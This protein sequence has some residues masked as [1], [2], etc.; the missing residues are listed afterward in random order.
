MAKLTPIINESFSQ[1]AGAVLQS[2]ALV[3]VRD[4]LKPSARQIFYCL[5]TDKFLPSKPFKKTLKAIGSIAR[6][7]IH[8]DASAEGVIM[9][10]SQPFAMRYPLVDVEGN[11]GHLQMSG[12]WA[13][14]RY[15]SSR[16]SPFSVC[17]FQDLEKNTITEW[18]DNYDDTE[19]YPTVLPSKGFYNIVN[20][21]FGIG[22]GAASSIP[23]FNLREVNNA[24]IKL[25]WNPDATFDEIYCVPDFATGA[26]LLNAD[27]VKEAMRRG[28]G[29]ACKLR[30]VIEYDEAERCLIVREIPFGVYTNTICKELDTLIERTDNPGIERYNDLTGQTINIKIYLSKRANL[31]R[32]LK[33][34]FKNTSLQSHYSINMTML[35]DG[36]FPKVFGWKA[37]LK[38]HLD[39]EIEV[40]RRGYQYDLDKA[41]DR[42]HIVEGII[43]AI[44][45]LEEVI[46]CIKGSSSTA[47]A[48]DE[49]CRRFEF[50][51]AQAEAILKITLAR[52][53]RLEVAKYENEAAELR[54]QI[55]WLEK[56]L[57]DD[58]TLL[59]QEIEKG[60]RQIASK[61]GDERRT[62]VLNIE[63]DEEEEPVD[64]KILT[65]YLTNY[66]NLYITE[67]S[68]LVKQARGG[69][70]KR[71]KLASDEVIT[72]S[73]IETNVK[74]ILL[75]SSLGRAF[76]CDLN[77]FP[78][79]QKINLNE[80]FA[81]EEDEIISYL[82]AN[83]SKD[84]FVFITREGLIKKTSVH[85]YE[86]RLKRGIS[87]IK[88][89]DGDSIVSI[90]EANDKDTIAIAT[91]D[92]HMTL[93]Q[94]N[95]VP[96]TGRVTSG[97][98]SMTLK[99][100]TKVQDAAIINIETKEIVTVTQKGFA[101]STSVDE[102]TVG[103]RG[104]RGILCHALKD[105]DKLA[106]F[107][108]ISATHR[109]QRRNLNVIASRSTIKIALSDIPLSGRNTVGLKT[110]KLRDD[111]QV[112][113]IFYE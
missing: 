63:R 58:H 35:E 43:R 70:G 30:S 109:E 36:R 107:V 98:K 25:L 69:V 79:D 7:Y 33:F 10:A 94:I 14:P 50:S 110:I 12:T 104:N 97:V 90:V 103:G 77:D 91:D 112:M 51:Y 53:A 86:G 73:A 100:L 60:F 113:E 52:L 99:N 56:V 47:N 17:L 71:V 74:P 82:T 95:E 78:I 59:Y 87:A 5:Y 84:Y 68:S 11:N 22:I 83:P 57:S 1:Y 27:E 4:C 44:S 28:T 41:R 29:A 18:R 24:L 55:E 23:Q 89:K 32:V 34:L 105:G 45:I 48:K 106:A 20:G 3:D 65:A 6:I 38:A 46:E 64:E 96:A 15:T 81:L 2:R 37:A 66:N 88:L 92:A 42:L 75:F 26:M 85:E 13:A 9:R 16:L 72:F 49:L 62:Q 108:P 54:T 80:H 31:A 93:F 39:H 76:K 61:F 102:F 111:E 67:T 21:T 8:G 40:Y 101:K 19:Q